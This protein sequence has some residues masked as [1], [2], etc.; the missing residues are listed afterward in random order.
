MFRLH[1][2]DKIH[3]VLSRLQTMVTSDDRSYLKLELPK[4]IELKDFDQNI[5]DNLKTKLDSVYREKEITVVVVFEQG[6]DKVIS[7]L[8][9]AKRSWKQPTLKF[10]IA[11]EHGVEYKGFTLP[12]VKITNPSVGL[13]GI[14]GRLNHICEI[15]HI[16]VTNLQMKVTDKEADGGYLWCN[17]IQSLP[18]P[19]KEAPKGVTLPQ[20]LSE[21]SV[22]EACKA[23]VETR[24]EVKLA[25]EAGRD[26]EPRDTLPPLE[27][28][29][30]LLQNTEESIKQMKITNNFYNIVKTE[31]REQQ[32]KKYDEKPR[33]RMNKDKFWS[34]T[35][36]QDHQERVK[37]YIENQNRLKE[38]EQ[39]QR[40]MK[41]EEE[42]INRLR[43]EEY[44]R[45]V[46]NEKQ[47]NHKK[48]PCYLERG[49]NLLD[50]SP[51]N[52]LNEALL[53]GL[54]SP[55]PQPHSA[56]VTSAHFPQAPP[57]PWSTPS[58][59]P[60]W[61]SRHEKI[62]WNNSQDLL[63]QARKLH[64]RAVF[65]KQQEEIEK[66]ERQHGIE[67]LARQQQEKEEQAKQQRANY[68]HFLLKAKQQQEREEYERFKNKEE[69]QLLQKA[70][71]Q[72]ERKEYE[73]FKNNIALVI[74][75]KNTEN[76]Y[77][78]IPDAPAPNSHD[79][80]LHVT[81]P[82]VT[83]PLVE[84]PTKQTKQPCDISMPPPDLRSSLGAAPTVH[85]SLSEQVSESPDWGGLKF[86]GPRFPSLE[87]D[88]VSDKKLPRPVDKKQIE[89][90][91][92]ITE[93]QLRE[94]TMLEGNI[95][96]TIYN[97]REN[98]PPC[99]LLADQNV[100]AASQCPQLLPGDNKQKI[101][102]MKEI[103]DLM[104]EKKQDH[105]Q[106]LQWLQKQPLHKIKELVKENGNGAWDTVE[107]DEENTDDDDNTVDDNDDDDDINDWVQEVQR[108]SARLANKTRIDYKKMNKKGKDDW[109]GQ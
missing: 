43:E 98:Q 81:M 30:N 4:T 91:R 40:R 102:S 17:W 22:K 28:A 11:L 32:K 33:Q 7:L 79:Q 68:E 108:A 54:S 61:D 12:L 15:L 78:E 25:R 14:A 36:E 45:R 64:E 52:L 46:E 55:P 73:R 19:Y 8:G 13:A 10:D 90:L 72:Q 66:Y 95:H 39:Y 51:S 84:N 65:L 101:N 38:D 74:N 109:W 1:V 49:K 105:I 41:R 2:S 76:Q 77:E 21:R 96:E 86:C 80:K 103:L 88:L 71:Q 100:I 63:E 57:Y 53:P 107:N 37:Q 23:I 35:E 6:E 94:I 106:T 9:V 85:K 69:K 82:N 16:S 93:D 48:N 58:Q 99:S 34:R 104:E 70:Q 3:H 87:K 50:S 31:E 89:V 59:N 67:K 75:K 20:W 83:K 27:F 26:Y 44:Q 62:Y 56:P 47:Q 92:R 18:P 5:K 24:K 97:T 42:N 29:Q 60:D